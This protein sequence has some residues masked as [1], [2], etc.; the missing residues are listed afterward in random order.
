MANRNNAGISS[1]RNNLG[2]DFNNFDNETMGIAGTEIFTFNSPS[3]FILNPGE[4]RSL[5]SRVEVDK[6]N[7][8]ELHL[9]NDAT[10]DVSIYWKLK[11]SD[12]PIFEETKSVNTINPPDSQNGIYAS[13][14]VRGRFIVIQITNTDVVPLTQWGVSIYA[15]K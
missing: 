9:Y 1:A 2:V 3:S 13:Q 5:F 7:F 11:P 4:T 10:F 6:H 15:R 14:R 8:L 12:D